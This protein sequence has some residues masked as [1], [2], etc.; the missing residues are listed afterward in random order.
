MKTRHRIPMIFSLSMMDVFC[1]TLGCVI[2][3]WLVNQR[4]A[5]L[6][7]RAASEAGSQLTD[8]RARLAAADRDR[9]DLRRQL[10]GLNADLDQSRRTTD[11]TRAD[12]AA[13]RAK[14]DDLTQKLTDLRAQAADTEDRLA[15]KTLA[16]QQLTRQQA[17]AQKRQGE[18]ERLVRDRELQNE[19]AARR[20]AELTER[21]EESDARAAQLKKVAD[22]LPD[23]R[24]AAAS[25]RESASAAATRVK[26]LERDLAD[27][28]GALE[29]ARGA[30]ESARTQSRD[31][32]GQMTRMRAAAEQRFEGIALTGRRVVF[33]VDMSGS[34]DLVDDRTRDASKWP[35][36]RETVLRIMRSLPQLE[37]FQIIMFSDRATFPMGQEGR[38][39]DYD[40]KASGDHVKAT[41]AAI[42][43]KGNTNMYAALEAAFQYRPQ[44]L[45]T[46]YL[47]SDGLP[48]IGVG[49]TAEQARTLGENQR[50][51]IL[52]RVVRTALKTRWNVPQPGR[53]RVRINA[54][55][56]FYE[57]PD[58]GAFLW[59]LARENDGSFVGM[60]R[61]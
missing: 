11:E 49:L 47:L 55:G 27:T 22:A 9:D 44:G 20:L 23:L 58:V 5:M 8:T 45:D 38:W 48:N 40:A 1:C 25:A 56:F 53:P 36:V 28:R 41:L 29:D 10:A 39:L 33:L 24:D 15:K 42:E 3:L 37:K 30:L 21:L 31:L 59:A 2:L 6:R 54:V 17:A 50:T 32:A 43:P 7:A 60:S 4:E 35:G 13:A 16:E 12:L 14:S 19:N 26:A 52:S 57:S 46:V 51:E 34:M 61:P 18:L